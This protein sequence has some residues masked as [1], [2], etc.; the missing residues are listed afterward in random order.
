MKTSTFLI[1]LSAA[2]AVLSFAACKK[3]AKDPVA[4]KGPRIVIA[5]TDTNVNRT[6]TVSKTITTSIRVMVV[7]ITGS[8][9]P[10]SIYK[11]SIH[12]NGDTSAMDNVRLYSEHG[13]P[14]GFAD[15]GPSTLTMILDSQIGFYPANYGDPSRVQ[16]QATI[17]PLKKTTVI[18]FSIDAADISSQPGVKV[19][20]KVASGQITLVPKG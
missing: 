19:T 12:A 10:S 2:I 1:T 4:E 9:G 11:L 16:L 18:S 5:T 14:Y 8:G 17:L 15:S 3:D 13:V 7:S 20:G 6:F